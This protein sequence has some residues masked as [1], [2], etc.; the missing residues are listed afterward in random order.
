VSAP[1]VVEMVV[2]AGLLFGIPDAGTVRT[3]PAALAAED[4][5][6][7]V[8]D[9]QAA[10]A[11]ELTAAQK[12]AMFFGIPDT[13]SDDIDDPGHWAQILGFC[14]ALAATSRPCSYD[15]G[16]PECQKA[17]ARGRPC[18]FSIVRALRWM[19]R[20]EPERSWTE[21]WGN[22]PECPPE[23]K[24]TWKLRCIPRG[25]LET[26]MWYPTWVPA[27]QPTGFERD[28]MWM[29]LRLE[30]AEH[31]LSPPPRVRAR[32]APAAPAWGPERIPAFAGQAL[33]ALRTSPLLGFVGQVEA[34][35]R[36]LAAVPATLIQRVREGR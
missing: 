9:G 8:D 24:D 32:P 13:G 19:E 17:Q 25:F 36:T 15:D 35:V 34:H 16:T 22:R 2:A 5:E 26:L 31:E 30:V 11:W 10:E 7:A 12:A 14:D 20:N 4:A 6:H 33:G 28:G 29:K 3:D 23:A 1:F 21:K 27:D 18:S